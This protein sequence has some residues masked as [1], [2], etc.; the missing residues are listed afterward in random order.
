MNY[1]SPHLSLFLLQLFLASLPRK[2]ERREAKGVKRREEGAESEEEGGRHPFQKMG[3]RFS[4]NPILG[5][6]TSSSH[7]VRTHPIFVGHHVPHKPF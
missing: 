4:Y 6:L 5:P 2:G 1:L 7:F 3:G